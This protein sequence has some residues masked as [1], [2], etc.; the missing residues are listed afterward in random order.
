MPY[1]SLNEEER[2]EFC[3]LMKKMLCNVGFTE[4]EVTVVL[5]KAQLAFQD[6]DYSVLL[7]GLLRSDICFWVIMLTEATIV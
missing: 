5:N 7:D 4:E 1:F 3:F 6:E 2:K